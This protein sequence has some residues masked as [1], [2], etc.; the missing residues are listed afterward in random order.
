MRSRESVSTIA[1]GV[2]SK[3]VSSIISRCTRA[4]RSSRSTSPMAL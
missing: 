1:V 4:L 2:A 3:T